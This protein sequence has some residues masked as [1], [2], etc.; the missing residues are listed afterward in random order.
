VAHPNSKKSKAARAKRAKDR[1]TRS[2]EQQSKSAE[3]REQ[4][5]VD[6]TQAA[7]GRRRRELRDRVLVTTGIVLVAG[8]MVAGLYVALKPDPEIAGVDHPTDR[9]GGHVESA[10]FDHDQPTSGPHSASA[11]NCRTYDEPLDSPLAVHALEHGTVVLWFD[12]AAPELADELEIE[13]KEWDSHV[14]ITPGVNMG[15]PVV[16]TAWNRRSSFDN[17]GDGVREFIDTYRLR[18]PED[19]SCGRA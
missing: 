7:K 13:A 1:Q 3:Q 10:G 16:A 11:P 5:Q 17:V 2:A 14:I 12:P 9:G 19:V 15:S 6:R 8:L 4:S 18:G